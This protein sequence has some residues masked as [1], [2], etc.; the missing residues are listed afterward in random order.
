MF[1]VSAMSFLYVDSSTQT[2]HENENPKFP[3]NKEKCLCFGKEDTQGSVH[4]NEWDGKYS[5]TGR[6]GVDNL[7]SFHNLVV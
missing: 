5:S 1:Y 2:K 3:L 6:G 4:E 7:R